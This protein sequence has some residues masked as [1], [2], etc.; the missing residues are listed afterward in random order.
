[1][2]LVLFTLARPVREWA[3]HHWHHLLFFVTVP[4]A[5]IGCG[6]AMGLWPKSGSDKERSE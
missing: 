3:G 5:L 2:A 1:M 6:A 4:L